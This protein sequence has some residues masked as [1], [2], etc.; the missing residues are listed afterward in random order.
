MASKWDEQ[1]ENQDSDEAEHE[2]RESKGQAKQKVLVPGVFVAAWTEIG[3]G[4][5]TVQYNVMIQL[6]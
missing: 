5:C 2:N 3:Q 4:A 1:L 6:Y